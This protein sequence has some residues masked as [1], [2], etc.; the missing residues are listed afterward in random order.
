MR[1]LKNYLK[2][3]HNITKHQNYCG[4]IYLSTEEYKNAIDIYT[5]AVKYYS[6]KFEIYYNLGISYAFINDFDVARKCFEETIKLNSNMYL[7]YFHLGQIALLYRDFEIAEYY[8][9]KSLCDEKEAKSYLELAKIHIIKNQKEKAI[10]DIDKAL[11]ADSSIYEEIQKEPVLIPIRK[12]ITKPNESTKNKYEETE[13]EKNVEQY[14]DNT[15]NLT[16]KLDD[17]EKANVIF[18]N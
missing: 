12:T 6:D 13:L 4:E 15:Y 10:T 18:N 7:A 11:K 3:S 14:L 2:I 1:C 8:F 17:N 16:K 5:N 9:S